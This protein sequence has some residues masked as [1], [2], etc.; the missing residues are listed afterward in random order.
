M[1]GTYFQPGSHEARVPA[2]AL[3]LVNGKVT[4]QAETAKT[5]ARAGG[6]PRSE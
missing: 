6:W 5:L 1:I 4:L 2:R 3:S